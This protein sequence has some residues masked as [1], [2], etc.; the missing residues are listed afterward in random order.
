M[1]PIKSYS[2]SIVDDMLQVFIVDMNDNEFILATICDCDNMF[3]YELDNL[4]QEIIEEN[5]YILIELE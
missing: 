3:D 1:T 5:D 4:A 2:Y